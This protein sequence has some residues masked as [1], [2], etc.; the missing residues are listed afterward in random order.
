MTRIE[1]VISPQVHLRGEVTPEVSAYAV[2]KVMA[3]LHHAPGPVLR[4]SLTLDAAAP[5]DRVDAHVNINGVGVH[6][7]GVGST[8]QEAADLMQERLRSRLHH[9]R[10]RPQQ[11]PR[12]PPPELGEP[13]G[14]TGAS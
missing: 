1:Q 10:R 12:I 4:A 7:H 9:L 6:V 11:G 13:I 5:G 2:A 14:V 8:M 3:V